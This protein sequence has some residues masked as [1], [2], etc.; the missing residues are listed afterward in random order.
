MNQQIVWGFHSRSRFPYKTYFIILRWIVP[1]NWTNCPSS[2]TI[3]CYFYDCKR[4]KS[5]IESYYENLPVFNSFMKSFK[6]ISANFRVSFPLCIEEEQKQIRLIECTKRKM[7]D[8][9]F[10]TGPYSMWDPYC[11]LYFS[12]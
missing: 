4:D 3:F 8:I 9:Q 12:S 11:H 5:D 6:P 7:I 2:W 10:L 1:D